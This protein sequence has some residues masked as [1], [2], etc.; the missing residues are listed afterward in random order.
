MSWIA[1]RDCSDL[2]RQDLS[3]RI[4]FDTLSGRAI[5]SRVARSAS[6]SLVQRQNQTAVMSRHFAPNGDSIGV[7]RVI[8]S[9][10]EIWLAAARART[11]AFKNPHPEAICNP[12]ESQP[13][14]L[15]RFH[16][17]IP[18]GQPRTARLPGDLIHWRRIPPAFRTLP[19]EVDAGY[20]LHSND[21][22]QPTFMSSAGNSGAKLRDL[23]NHNLRPN[24]E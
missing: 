12:I 5:R 21:P 2:S 23:C 16:P 4:S 19:F 18:T 6:V 1:C 17:T 22:L 11:C 7:R 15:M 24:L 14:R 10:A 9:A 8:A 3:R 20:D 13:E